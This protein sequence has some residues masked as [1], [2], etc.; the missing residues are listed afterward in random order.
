MDYLKS[1]ETDKRYSIFPVAHQDLWNFYKDA[2]AQHWVAQETDFSM[3]DY[4]SLKPE[5]KE[6]LKAI[7]AFFTVSDGLVIDNLCINFMQEANILEAQYYYSEQAVIEQVHAETYSL[8]IDTYIK[9][10]QEK[11]DLFNAMETNVAVQ[12]KVAWAEKW[13][14]HPSFGVR[15]VAFAL[16]EGLSFSSVFGGVFWFRSRNLMTGMGEA[17]ELIIKDETSH[18]NFAVYLYKNYL[19]DEYKLDKDEIKQMVLECFETEKTFVEESMPTGL[20]GLT[21]EMMIQY[22]QFVADTILI[23]YDIEP[24]FNISNPLEYMSRIGVAAKNNFFEKSV[25]EYT[26][27]DF[28]EDIETEDF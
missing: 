2:E 14:D 27:L 10:K 1:N 16:V 19:K 6:Y 7:L 5:E 28:D 26:T 13:I 9:D 11:A 23:E 24:V 3:D 18:Y 20:A 15:L 4:D 21:K 12:K 25:G 22:V 8:L 17:N